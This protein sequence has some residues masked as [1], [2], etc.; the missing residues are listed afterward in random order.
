MS[1]TSSD[2][3]DGGEIPLAHVYPRC[4]GQ[5]ISPA[6]SW[7]GVP[8]TAQTLLLTM[9][10]IDV[11][12]ALWTH[13][14]VVYLPPD[15][16]GLERG[17]QTLPRGAHAVQSNFGDTFY[18]GPCPRDDSGVH[19]YRFTLWAL[20]RYSDVPPN[21]NAVDLQTA[22]GRLAVDKATITGWVKR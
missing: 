17:T 3:A 18:D 15:S 6:L 8:K 21:A 5:N 13:W 11:R 19:H 9:I 20:P 2:F 7:K 10:D 16:A 1:L 12:P 22:L 14:V 4:G